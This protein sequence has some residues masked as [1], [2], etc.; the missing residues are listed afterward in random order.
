MIP[1]DVLDTRVVK[2]PSDS[3]EKS[4]APKPVPYFPQQTI[5]WC[6]AA[7]TQM[8]VAAHQTRYPSQCDLANM[9]FGRQDCCGN[10]MP[11]PCDQ[12]YDDLC[13]LFVTMQFNC[14]S[15]PYP[16]TPNEVLNQTEAGRPIIYNILW[17]AQGAQHAGVISDYRRAGDVDEV[18]FLDPDLAFFQQWGRNPYGWVRYDWVLNG[19]GF[20]GNW[21]TSWYDIEQ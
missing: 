16:L 21:T 7:C 17:G 19:Y 11:A 8:V 12:G 5:N 4:L 10:P 6:W 15:Q 2:P 20:G 1:H 3:L 14:R 18:Y 13:H 9:A